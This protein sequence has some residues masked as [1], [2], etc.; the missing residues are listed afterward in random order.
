MTG[1]IMVK[2]SIDE[3]QAEL[4]LEPNHPRN[5]NDD[6]NVDNNGDIVVSS[7]TMPESSML[8]MVNDYTY[9]CV[10]I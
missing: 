8:P 1:E 3:A 4:L 7:H 6:D 5:C 9:V 2:R 10:F